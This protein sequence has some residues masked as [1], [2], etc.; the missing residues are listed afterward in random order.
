MAQSQ[1]TNHLLVGSSCSPFTNNLSIPLQV[2]TSEGFLKTAETD[3]SRNGSYEM[4][5]QHHGNY[6]NDVM[7]AND[8]LELEIA[9]L[10]AS[11]YGFD[12]GNSNPWYRGL[13]PDI[14]SGLEVLDQP[15][16]YS[17]V[18]LPLRRGSGTGTGVNTRAKKIQQSFELK[19]FCL[20][21]IEPFKY[22]LQSPFADL[23]EDLGGMEYP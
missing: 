10:K 18:T 6:I 4:M 14:D 13:G 3:I 19:S 8:D 9:Q 15:I 1:N 2:S 22:A 7:Q 11:W 12:C 5:A 16:G 23:E 21:R 17:G 20:E